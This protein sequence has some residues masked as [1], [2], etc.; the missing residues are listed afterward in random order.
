MSQHSLTDRLKSDPRQWWLVITSGTLTLVCGSIGLW[1]YEHAHAEHAVNPVTC[2]FS[3]LYY[4]LQM[5]ILHT[6]HFE[7]GTNV[8]LEIGRWSGAFTLVSATL[9]VFWK[10]LRH[11]FQLLRLTSWSGHHVVCGL[12][13][14]GME[15][16]RG[17]KPEGSAARVVVIDPNPEASFVNECS[18]KGVPVLMGD[19]TVAKSLNKARVHS[20]REIIVITPKDETNVRIAGEVRQLSAK[21][22][23][24]GQ[25]C[26]VHLENIHLREGLQKFT[27]L[28]SSTGCTLKFFDV[29]DGEARRVLSESPLD[30]QGIGPK[31]PRTVHLVIVGFGRM[32]RSLALRA[33]K[34]GHFAN[35]KQ[36]RISVIDREAERQREHFLFR[37]PAL[38]SDKICQLIFHPADA[39]SLTARRLIEGWA[40]EPDTLLH[41][42]ICV[43]DNTTAVEVGLRLQAM[44]V[45][46]P[47][48]NLQLRIKQRA[49]L[50]KILEQSAQSTRPH[51]KVFG[52]VEDT[53]CDTV[54]RHE[55]NERIAQSLHESFVEKR[56]ANSNRTLDN[57]PAMQPWA[58]LLDDFRESNRQQADHMGIKLRALGL[59]MTLAA[60]TREAITTFSAADIE[61]LAEVEHRRWNAERWLA[62]W[63][64]GKPSDKPNRINEYLVAWNE[65]PDS[66][67]QYD[68]ET[69]TGMPN[70]LA[71]AQMKV[72]RQ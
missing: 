30:G 10:G 8:C 32:G 48:C 44:L 57:D 6:P 40:A 1:Q 21:N 17:L 35:G 37:Y 46:H 34:M 69:I 14:K 50:A 38:E 54:F 55:F 16:V 66:I 31:D 25:A 52:M 15:I 67:K 36:L 2:A 43:D 62:G 23:P 41:L 60:D 65:L 47:D 61:L 26:Y 19:A 49:S 5:L 72:V 12:G 51:L 59:E 24:A 3:S 29:F 64:Y 13:Q 63:R 39:Q 22:Q 45:R 27:N 58:T 71:A 33:A 56:L 7:R 4:A 11:E 20:A 9:I 70:R 42:F 68:R 18:A 53:C 28:S